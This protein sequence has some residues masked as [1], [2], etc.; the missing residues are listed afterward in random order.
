MEIGIGLPG[1]IPGALAS[2][3][4]PWAQ[5]ADGGPFSS[6]SVIDRLVYS[7]FDTMI[8]LAVAAGATQ[9]VRLMT[10]VLLSPL[11]S[12]A[13]L[14]KEAATLDAL[15]GGRLTLGVGI[16]SRPEDFAAVDVPFDKRGRI[17]DEQLATMKRVW[18]GQPMS[19]T[20]G[21]IGPAPARAGGPPLLIGGFSPSA[22]RRVGQW[23]DGYIATVVDPG[24]A[25]QLFAQAQ[26]EWQAAGRTGRPRFVMSL[27]YALG[28]DANERGRRYLD[29]YYAFDPHMGPLIASS[30]LSTPDAITGALRAYEGIGVDEITF[31]PTIAE[32]EQVNL[33]ADVIG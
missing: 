31:W 6:L 13:V 16:G 28:P 19:E 21:E 14:A 8:T 7:N 22:M 26:G 12:A 1:T 27:Y 18:A 3:L 20:V 11:R 32:L 10:S 25:S 4:V 17:F 9:R 23:G 33:L 2:D 15:S 30:I 5:R 29:A 24:T